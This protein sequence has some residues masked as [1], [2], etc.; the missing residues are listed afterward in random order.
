MRSLRFTVAKNA[1]ANV[2]RGGAS[3]VVA[4]MLPHFL[5]HSL[6][7][8]RFAGW[9]L[10]L[11]LAAYA[12]Y[13][14]FGVQ[15][16]V[17]RYLAAALEA[18]D[19]QQRDRL[20]SNAFAILIAAGII[21]LCG[22]GIVAWQ[23]PHLF[24]SVPVA[25]AAEIGSGLLILG[26]AAAINLPLSAY[27]GVLIGMQ[28]NEFPAIAIATS[29]FFGTVAV[30]LAVHRTHSL[31]LL[32]ACIGGFNLVAGLI[33]CVIV[34]KL[35]PSLRFSFA[36]L[37]RA[38]AAELIRYCSTLSV[39]SFAML[40]V[41]GLDVTIIG[42]FNFQAVGAY[43]IAATLIMFFTGLIG[44]AFS[45]VLAPVAVLQARQ[46]FDRISRLVIVT[47]RLN[48]YF[49]MGVIVLAFLFGDSLIRAWVGPTYLA[50][51]L[52]VLKILLIAQAVRLVGNGYG[53]VL[54]GMGLQSY[55]L[56]PALI[57]GVS[58]LA[59]S[60]LAIIVIGPIGVAWATLVA[61]VIAVAIVAFAVLPKIR[62]L[63]ID[64]G[65][66][67]WQG[68]G[69][70]LLPYLPVFLILLCRAW[71]ERRVHL[72]Y[73]ERCLPVFLSLIFAGW[74]I[75]DGVRR[76]LREVTSTAIAPKMGLDNMRA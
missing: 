33:Q 62:C 38:T 2:I 39:W 8:D 24:R 32:A 44:A 9:A 19:Q 25:L 4:I 10:M 75:W 11:Q 52:P 21:A 71:L 72:S 51:T 18:D 15:T 67:L 36:F 41:S 7:P 58:N 68:L 30:I 47:T 46:E 57:E 43:S 34:K 13:L 73:M 22:L 60:L 14:D 49:S 65:S 63:S 40:L 6:G 45:A 20:F 29:R 64:S 17:A 3:A 16:A 35:L 48:S 70:P 26:F 56:L 69:I 59:L 28:R 5:T 42:F 55:G 74:R 54:V 37:D 66:F 50:L 12:N 31:A 1:V 23:L 27:T 53:V 76:T 61:A